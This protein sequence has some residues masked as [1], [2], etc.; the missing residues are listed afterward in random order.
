MAYSQQLALACSQIRKK[1]TSRLQHGSRIR[2]SCTPG[3]WRIYRADLP[4]TRMYA[5]IY[6]Y[7]YVIRI[8]TSQPYST[9]VRNFGGCVLLVIG[10]CLLATIPRA[11][12]SSEGNRLRYLSDL[13][14]VVA[15]RRVHT[16]AC[17]LHCSFVRWSQSPCTVYLAVV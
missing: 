16:L 7:T 4:W 5:G 14:N 10:Y 6:A 13:F 11:G 8:R 3:F 1:I 2:Q 12:W 9:V 17:R 15:T